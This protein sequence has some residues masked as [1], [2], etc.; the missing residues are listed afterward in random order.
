MSRCLDVLSVRSL[1]AKWVGEP[2][3]PTGRPVTAHDLLV[4]MAADLDSGRTTGD[5]RDA[6]DR[7]EI[8]AGMLADLHDPRLIITPDYVGPARRLVDHRGR[9]SPHHRSECRHGGH[10]GWAARR[11]GSGAI[12]STSIRRLVVAVALTAA[13]VAPLTLALSHWIAL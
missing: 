3:V 10:P 1:V 6:I 7:I 4:P 5:D 8:P 12:P 13:T 9:T 11:H 2:Q